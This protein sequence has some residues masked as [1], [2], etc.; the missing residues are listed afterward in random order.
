MKRTGNQFRV[1]M[2]LRKLSR[3]DFLKLP[4]LVIPNLFRDL[5]VDLIQGRVHDL[6]R[7]TKDGFSQRSAALM[8]P[9]IPYFRSGLLVREANS[10]CS[11]SALTYSAQPTTA[12]NVYEEI[13]AEANDHG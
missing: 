3:H 9:V 7:A 8:D 11:F 4:L 12:H 1:S 5:G 13:L 6:G 2:Q 10:R